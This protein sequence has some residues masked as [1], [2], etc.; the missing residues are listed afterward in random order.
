[1]ASEGRAS[2]STSPP[3][4]LR[5]TT[6]AWNVFST[7][8]WT[9]IASTWAPSARSRPQQVVG[10]RPRRLDALE[11]EGDGVGLEDPDPDREEEVL[12][13]LLEDHDRGVGHRDRGSG[14]GSRRRAGP[15]RCRGSR[16]HPQCQAAPRRVKPRDRPAIPLRDAHAE[17]ARGRSRRSPRRGDLAGPIPF[18][19][20][21]LTTRLSAP[22]PARLG[23]A[24]R[25][26]VDQDLNVALP[27]RA[28]LS[29]SWIAACRAKSRSSAPGDGLRHATAVAGRR[30]PRPR[31]E[32]E[33]V[34]LTEAHPRTTSSVASKS[35]SLSPGKPTMTSVERVTSGIAPQLRGP[36][37]GSRPRV[38]AAHSFEHGVRPRLE[39]H[40]QVACPHSGSRRSPRSS[41]R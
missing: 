15:S 8:E 5:S 13:R 37:R 12:V 1:M 22:L 25:W 9:T 26:T 32:D 7:R 21:K 17:Q 3:C 36:G 23:A 35:A 27:M 30:R 40:V 38:A 6:L 24:L 14:R 20:G 28:W 4:A 16:S 18:H 41:C 33:A 29:S 19:A 11:L 31:R 2:T 34:E 10:H 39:R